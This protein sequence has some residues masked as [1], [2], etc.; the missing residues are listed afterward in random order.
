MSL[1]DDDLS[2]PFSKE[3]FKKLQTVVYA[4]NNKLD[5]VEDKLYLLRFKLA[6]LHNIDIDLIDDSTDLELY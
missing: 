6:R 3:N 4:L 2:L 1:Y 5:M